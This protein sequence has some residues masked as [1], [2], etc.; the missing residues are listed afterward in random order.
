M[1][2]SLVGVGLSAGTHQLYVS[3]GGDSF[4]PAG[5]SAPATLNVLPTPV[6]LTLS[7]SKAQIVAGSVF[8]CAVKAD[9]LIGPA[10]GSITYAL[11]GGS[12]VALPLGAGRATV[13]FPN[14]AVGSHSLVVRY[15]AQTNYGTANP[16]TERF[17]V[18]GLP[19]Q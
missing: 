5:L 4:N 7:C 17:T 9:S 8:A 16:V 19:T 2:L 18:T 13:T 6:G 12:P 15:P 1:V 3:Y 14:P 11:D 10:Q